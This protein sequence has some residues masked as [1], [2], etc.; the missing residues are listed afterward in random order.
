[1]D[2]ATFELFRSA[3]RV[4][5]TSFPADQGNCEIID[6]DDKH[7]ASAVQTTYKFRRTDESGVMVGY[8][9]NLYPTNNRVLMNGKDI[10]S[11]MDSHL[12][13][14][15]YIMCT[16][17]R[18]G[19]INSANQL[20][21]ILETQLN[22]VLNERQNKALPNHDRQK[23]SDSEENQNKNETNCD[24]HDKTESRSEPVTGNS[25]KPTPEAK[26]PGCSR[27]CLKRGAVCEI[28]NHWIHYRCDKLTE[29]EI[30][31]LEKDP[32][33]IYSCKRC[34]TENTI[35][36]QPAQQ[37]DKTSVNFMNTS[38]AVEPLVLPSINNDYATNNTSTEA[39]GILEEEQGSVCCVCD[40]RI[41]DTGTTCSKCNNP[42]HEGCAISSEGIDQCIAC[43]ATDS[44]FSKENN[45]NSFRGC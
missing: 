3:C 40:D 18:S 35:V 13:T 2:T 44:Q 15:H 9:L 37:V 20:N 11:F 21:V 17:I 31:R 29:A 6:C 45:N 27:N 5:Y 28:G 32:G 14:L 1:M 33:F 41:T 36:K 7:S 39:A 12:P 26:C 19:Q 24:L 16:P 42:C 8:T 25:G 4:F 30:Q 23:Q 10:N 34:Q 43:S 22:A 38:G